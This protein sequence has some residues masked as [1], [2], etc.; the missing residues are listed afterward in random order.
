MANSVGLVQSAIWMSDEFC[1]LSGDA[2]RLYLFLISQDDVSLCGVLALRANRWAASAADWNAQRVRKSLAELERARFVVV[3]HDTEEVLIRT[4][5]RHSGALRLP[6][7][8]VGVMK[9]FALIRSHV[10]RRAV[11]E[12]LP[13]DVMERTEKAKP[14]KWTAAFESEWKRFQEA[15]E[16]PSG[17]P[18]PKG[19]AN[20]SGNGSVDGLEDPFGNPPQTLTGTNKQT[21]LGTFE[22]QVGGSLT[23]VAAGPSDPPHASLGSPLVAARQALVAG[24][25]SRIGVA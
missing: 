5:V 2:Q 6:N 25:R 9:Q 22:L 20:P 4:Y 18:L 8:V 16:N 7:V 15:S 10:L 13:D 24:N 23:G 1:G 11:L 17:N 12:T 21:D 19:L 3:D 14:S